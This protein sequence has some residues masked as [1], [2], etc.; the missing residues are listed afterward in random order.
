MFCD[1]HSDLGVS[2]KPFWYGLKLPKNDCFSG[3]EFVIVT[4]KA[5][6]AIF[7]IRSFPVV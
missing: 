2:T 6:P 5:C 3:V 1:L 4:E 7:K